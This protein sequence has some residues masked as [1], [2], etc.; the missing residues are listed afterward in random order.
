MARNHPEPGRE[1]SAASDFV[2]P[3]HRFDPL[4]VSLG[5]EVNDVPRSAKLAMESASPA[6]GGDA[7]RTV[8][9]RDPRVPDRRSGRTR[10]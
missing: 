2:V 4:P 7:D 6:A 8:P 10:S 1:S 3:M 9:L 5:C